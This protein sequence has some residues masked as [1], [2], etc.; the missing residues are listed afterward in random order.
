M[1]EIVLEEVEMRKRSCL[2]HVK[3]E[4]VRDRMPGGL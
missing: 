3:N 2:W 1:G 4:A